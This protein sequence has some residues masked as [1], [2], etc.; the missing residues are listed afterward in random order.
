MIRRCFSLLFPWSILILLSLFHLKPYSSTQ[1][2]KAHH[3]YQKHLVLAYYSHLKNHEFHETMA[4]QYPQVRTFICPQKHI[5]CLTRR[6][7]D[8]QL[9]DFGTKF[10][11]PPIQNFK[12]HHLHAVHYHDT[13]GI[14]RW[15]QITN[16]QPSIYAL[17]ITQ[18]NEANNATHVLLY[19]RSSIHSQHNNKDQ[20]RD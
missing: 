5:R 11:P 9:I 3:T 10:Q 19:Q 20:H 4:Q 2:N 12:I 1:Y 14:K 16:K 15:H 7:L 18:T 13:K 6:N 8:S 17:D